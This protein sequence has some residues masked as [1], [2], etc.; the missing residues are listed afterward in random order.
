MGFEAPYR[1]APGTHARRHWEF[2]CTGP[3]PSA[4]AL[5]RDS[6]FR[7]CATCS[8]PSLWPGWRSPCGSTSSRT[9]A[10]SSR[11]STPRSICTR[12][13]TMRAWF[14]E[15]WAAWAKP[16]EYAA[17]S[18]QGLL[19]VLIGFLGR[20]LPLRPQMVGGLFAL[21]DALGC[22]M[23]VLD[24]P[25]PRGATLG[26]CG[27]RRCAGDPHPQ[28]HRLRGH[29]STA[30]PSFRPRCCR[31]GVHPGLHVGS[32]TVSVDRRRHG[33]LPGCRIHDRD[34]AAFRVDHPG[35]RRALLLQEGAL[36]PARQGPGSGRCSQ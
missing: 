27:R 4:L 8:A 33:S 5:A 19:P 14:S 10:G 30:P 32:A 28:R 6:G 36:P 9:K 2:G 16:L 13:Q 35:G 23:I 17:L 18:Q 3:C 21:L 25:A 31:V 12:G 7:P 1:R 24:G 34:D 26:L 29:S 15:P 20:L 11:S 22:A